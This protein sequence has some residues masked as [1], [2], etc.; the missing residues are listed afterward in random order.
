MPEHV[1]V[2]VPDEVRR[3]GL[4]LVAIKTELKWHRWLLLVLLAAVLSGVRVMDSFS[5]IPWHP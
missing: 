4:D 3:H 2:S 1:K 5:A